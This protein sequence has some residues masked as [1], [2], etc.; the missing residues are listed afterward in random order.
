ML[1]TSEKLNREQTVTS[2]YNA[3]N[4]IQ[5][6]FKMDFNKLFTSN[7]RPSD[8]ILS[9]YNNTPLAEELCRENSSTKTV[10][11]NI[12]KIFF[13][14]MYIQAIQIYIHV[15][16]QHKKKKLFSIQSKFM[17]IKPQVFL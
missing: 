14:S 4:N 2:D 12:N 8:Y 5:K 6:N 10:E 1:T 7:V 11:K 15:F 17:Y 16:G 9:I 13:P 3:S